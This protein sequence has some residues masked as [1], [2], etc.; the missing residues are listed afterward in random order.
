MDVTQQDWDEHITWLPR[1]DQLQI[2]SGMS[3][4]L[5]DKTCVI[6]ATTNPDYQRESKE[7]VGLCVVMHTIYNKQWDG[8]DWIKEVNNA[9]V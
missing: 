2:L 3:W 5:F 8:T 1:Q 9:E 6:W 7:I 4:Y